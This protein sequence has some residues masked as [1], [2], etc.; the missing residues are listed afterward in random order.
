MEGMGPPPAVGGPGPARR[1]RGLMREQNR[2][3]RPRPWL[4]PHIFTLKPGGSEWRIG[5]FE[6][7]Q[8][9][10][11]LAINLEG[12]NRDLAG[13]RTSFLVALPF[14]LLL[15]A[16]GG[17]LIA[18]QALVPVRTLTRA[19]ERIT[20]RGL[21]QRISDVSSAPEFRRLIQVFNEML[22]RLETSF[23]QAIR[24]SA[25]ASH[26]LKTPL[27]VMQG[28]IEQAMHAAENA[29]EQQRVL[30]NLMEQA[31][32]LKDIT[33]RL[34]LL[35]Q[36]D[37][38]RLPLSLEDVD[39]SEELETLAEDAGA[40]AETAGL[41]FRSRIPAGC[42]I[43]IDVNMVRMAIMN[44]LSNAVKYNVAGG[45]VDCRLLV[46]AS[47]ARL[48][49]SNS[50]PGIPKEIQAQVFE[51]FHRGYARKVSPTEGFGLGLGLAREIARAHGGD[52]VLVESN[53]EETVFELVLPRNG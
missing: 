44:L 22:D 46:E 19:A 40:M 35:S 36:A 11:F 53:A 18:R 13:I 5:V 49:I 42:M 50:G 26:E 4:N 23:G 38:G 14:A 34:L 6:T 31:Q 25:D 7:P 10:L 21:D 20:A 45:Y 27:T 37:S 2:P 8:L 32:R 28:E 33:R 24:F 52:V 15:I 39:L 47:W 48:R 43:H 16:A 1:F 9:R 30:N 12:V 29:P 51:R 3:G 17:L 41:E